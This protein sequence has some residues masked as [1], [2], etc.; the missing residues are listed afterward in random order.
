[1]SDSS[2]EEHVHKQTGKNYTIDLKAF[3]RS[4]LRLEAELRDTS[5]CNDIIDAYCSDIT[6]YKDINP[7]ISGDGIFPLITEIYKHSANEGTIPTCWGK[8]CVLTE[9]GAAL[10]DDIKGDGA[11]VVRQTT[12]GETSGT[13]LATPTQM[14]Y[15]PAKAWRI[16]QGERWRGRNWN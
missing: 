4:K 7:L 15:H 3:H 13:S 12:Y 9:M 16:H 1:M 11:E 6:P 8:L 5:S 10:I 14:H 2:D